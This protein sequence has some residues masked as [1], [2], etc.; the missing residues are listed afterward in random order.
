MS[1]RLSEVVDPAL[2][3]SYLGADASR[4]LQIGLLC[5]QASAELRPSMSIVVEMLTANISIP[6][7]T[8]PPFLSSNVEIPSAF[9]EINH[10]RP[11]SSTLSSGNTISVSLFDPR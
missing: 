1:N 4:V 10:S 3:G 6:S 8:Q 9:R 11:E 5:T 2:E 7:P